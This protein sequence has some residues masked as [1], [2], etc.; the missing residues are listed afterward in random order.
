MA[1]KTGQIGNNR[2][3]QR[4]QDNYERDSQDRRPWVGEWDRTAGTCQ[5]EE[6]GLASSLTDQLRQDREDRMARIRHQGMDNVTN[7]QSWAYCAEER[8][9][10][11]TQAFFCC[12]ATK[13]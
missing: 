9:S 10:A 3:G 7:E 11:I 2:M 8:N 4:W 1:A 13:T 5:S 12:A 6:A